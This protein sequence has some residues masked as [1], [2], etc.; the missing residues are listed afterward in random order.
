MQIVI[1]EKGSIEGYTAA[2]VARRALKND[3]ELIFIEHG[4]KVPDVVKGMTVKMF[5][6][7]FSRAVTESLQ[8]ICDL[9]VFDNCMISR[10]Q[11]G[12]MKNVRINLRQTPAKLAWDHYRPDFRVLVGHNRQEK[13]HFDTAP[14]IVNYS[15]RKDL[16]KWPDVSKEFVK[17]AIK[18]NYPMTL[19]SWDELAT[20]D[21]LAIADEGKYLTM[22]LTTGEETQNDD[23]Q[24]AGV[25]RRNSRRKSS[26][27]VAGAA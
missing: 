22:S 17:F 23:N 4:D 24:S 25:R 18:T 13:F 7:S 3:C 12:G 11:L 6:V 5:G 20:R 15:E 26:A 2:W 10:A 19:E 27:A 1:V 9:H 8:K 21:M 16:W 14:W